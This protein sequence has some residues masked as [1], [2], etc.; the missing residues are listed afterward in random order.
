MTSEAQA[1]VDEGPAG[2]PLDELVGYLDRYLDI[3]AFK[4]PSDNGLQIEGRPTVRRL[5]CA[6]DAA[7]PTLQAAAEGGADLLLTHH[8]LFWGQPIMVRG[9]HRRRLQA[10]LDAELS[11]YAAHLPLDA[12][13]EVGNNAVLAGALS[14]QNLQPFGEFAG[15]KIGV[16][17]E[18]PFALGLQDLAERIQRLT[19][20]VALVH[21]GG[22]G[23]ARRVAVVSGAAG[24]QIGAA[25]R[26]G[27]DTLITGE[28]KH[29]HFHDPFEHGVNVLYA[30][31]YDTEVFGVRALCAHLEDRFGLPWQF[32]HHP[33]GL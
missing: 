7:L 2:V 26:A 27:F 18:L 22:P 9:A 15:Q 24:D 19:G 23:E 20:E 28:P 5:A 17:G 21:G 14:L 16:G 29:Q 1:Q 30:G 13:P 31:H 32:L 10:A 25:A 8:G 3:A 6:V 11:V 33:S 4:D 12:H